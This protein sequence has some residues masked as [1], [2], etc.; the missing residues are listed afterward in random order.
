MT[1]DGNSFLK[2]AYRTQSVESCTMSALFFTIEEWKWKIW[3]SGTLT[4]HTF[5]LFGINVENQI[6]QILYN[7]Q[8]RFY[9]FFNY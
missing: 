6:V 9:F 8:N 2:I 3:K 1:R 5:Q 4:S 7:F